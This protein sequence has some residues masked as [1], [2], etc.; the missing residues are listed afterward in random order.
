MYKIS[1]GF[2][3]GTA[4]VSR[5]FL[6]I[7]VAAVRALFTALEH[8]L[9]HTAGKVRDQFPGRGKGILDMLKGNSHGGL[10]VKG[11]AARQHLIQSDAQRIDIALFVTV[12]A[13]CLL[14]RSIVDRPHDIGCDRVAGGGLGDAEVR[15][16][17]LALLGNNDILRFDIPVDD[18]VA[19]G[20]RQSHRDL[21]GDRH[22]LARYKPFFFLNIALERDPVDQLHDDVVGAFFLAHIIDIDNIRVH[23]TGSRLC[24]HAEFGYKRRVLGKLL[25]EHLDSHHAVEPVVL[26]LIYIGHAAGTDLF[27]H[28]VAV[29][30]QHTY[31]Y[32]MILRTL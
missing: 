1:V 22:G 12:A 25:F 23:Q 13:P 24:F 4:K 11:H 31:L 30:N 5:E 32:H 3:E 28:L 7:L 8:D 17:D 10:P 14:R 20:C 21:D 18:V 2:I 19:V 16:L 9:L 15:H 27:Q 6:H 26:C 29:R